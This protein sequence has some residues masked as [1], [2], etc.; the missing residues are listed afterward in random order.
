[1]TTYKP[2]SNPL[3]KLRDEYANSVLPRHVSFFGALPAPVSYYEKIEKPS[4]EINNNGRITYSN[5]FFGKVINTMEEMV[6]V[7]N[8]LNKKLA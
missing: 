8:K 3:W 4:M 1:M 2:V 6:E 5:Y 7:A